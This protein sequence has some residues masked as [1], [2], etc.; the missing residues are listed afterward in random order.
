[1]AGLMLWVALLVVP[2]RA[3]GQAAQRGGEL[4]EA[5]FAEALRASMLGFLA[6]AWFLSRTYQPLLYLLLGLCM[7]A[8]WCVR[9]AALA[10]GAPLAPT[11]WML[12]TVVAATG[13][14]VLVY[15]F[16]LV[17]RAAG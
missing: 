15:G 10:Q 4:R 16:V 2:F 5:D 1:L 14:I 6:C 3:L 17:E 12:A 11:R 9:Q 13:S 8:A 7:A